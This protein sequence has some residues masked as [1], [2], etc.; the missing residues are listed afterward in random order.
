MDSAFCDISFADKKLQ[1]IKVTSQLMNSIWSSLI[2]GL[3]VAFP[4]LLWEIW[5]VWLQLLG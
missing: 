3:I 4:Y 1:S 5:L 2:L